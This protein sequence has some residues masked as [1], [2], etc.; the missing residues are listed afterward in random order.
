MRGE[1]CTSFVSNHSAF[2]SR[3]T[4]H[5]FLGVFL[6]LLLAALPL[7]AAP[8]AL[9][10]A[11][12]HY[13]VIDPPQPVQKGNGVEVLELLWYGCRTC[14]VLQPELERWR[15]A[16]REQ[17]HYRRMPAITNEQMIML[18]RAFYAAQALGVEERVH[19]ALFA[20]IHRHRRHLDSEAAL[21]EFFAEQGVEPAAF[22]NAFR[23]NFT[24]RKVRQARIMSKRYGIQ[25]AP[26]II[27]AG[28]YRVD[29][30]MV[31]SVEEMTAVLDFLL[32]KAQN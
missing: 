19:G 31:R 17:I 16:H 6:L 5:A 25:G 7:Q 26:S 1:A 2:S 11:G 32:A 23:S 15:A 3:L 21:T 18:A 10:Q 8:P 28:R 22:R 14:F 27:I 24:A 4:P 12:V 9:F 13:Q 30:S 20:A 29:P